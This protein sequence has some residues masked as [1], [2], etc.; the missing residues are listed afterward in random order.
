M[1]YSCGEHHSLPLISFS[2]EAPFHLGAPGTPEN[3]TLIAG[4]RAV[5]QKPSFSELTL[6]S[7]TSLSQFSK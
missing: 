3:Q 2:L 1:S 7:T 6:R 5:I 4:F